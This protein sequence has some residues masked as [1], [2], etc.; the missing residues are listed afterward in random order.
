MKKNLFVIASVAILGGVLTFSSCKKED[1]TAP[2]LSITGGNDQ[3]FS[4][5][6]SF[7]NPTATATDDQDG[8][9]S[10]KISVTGTVD[11]N[12]KG[13]YTLTYSVSDAAGNT[14]SQDVTIHIVNDAEFLAGTYAADDTCQVSWVSPYTMS[15]STSNTVNDAITVNNLSNFGTGINLN[16]TVNI[17]GSSITFS[18]PQTIGSLGSLN[19]GSGTYTHNGTAVNANLVWQWTDG[20]NTEVC[21]TT[22]SK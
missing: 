15:M 16:A 7:T 13:N 6:S 1:T 8:D 18:A 4:L 14:A 9:V 22:A 17:S 19:S 10:T 5:N 12:T 20:T 3:T 2:T 21:T 11:A